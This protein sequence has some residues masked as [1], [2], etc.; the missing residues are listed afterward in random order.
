[1]YIH[2]NESAYSLGPPS[3]CRALRVADFLRWIWQLH[4]KRTPSHTPHNKSHNCSLRRGKT[5]VSNQKDRTFQREGI[6]RNAESN[7]K[8]FLAVYFPSQSNTHRLGHTHTYC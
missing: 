1:M 6:K 7:A 2:A 3:D 8:V 4:K 5:K